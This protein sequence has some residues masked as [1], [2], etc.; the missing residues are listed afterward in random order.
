[1][2]LRLTEPVTETENLTPLE[3]AE[4]NSRDT[5]GVF[6]SGLQRA[7]LITQVLK[8]NGK[9]LV[10]T[11]SVVPGDSGSGLFSCRDDTFMGVAVRRGVI[12]LKK[13]DPPLSP[14]GKP[15]EEDEDGPDTGVFPFPDA[16]Y[17]TFGE[18]LNNFL[19]K[20]WPNYRQ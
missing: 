13:E 19:A 14:S 8:H 17:F 9:L 4:I 2:L 3:I 6:A 16:A 20:H 10:A 15:P 12:N 18:D 1:V 5:I 7:S 11:P